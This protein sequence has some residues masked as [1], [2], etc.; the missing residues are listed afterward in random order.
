MA[1]KFRKQHRDSLKLKIKRAVKNLAAG[2]FNT[3]SSQVQ[4]F[5][6][7]KFKFKLIMLSAITIVLTAV[8]TIWYLWEVPLLSPLSSLSNFQFLPAV[9]NKQTQQQRIVYGF[10]PYWNL[11][12]VS[13]Q[14]ELTHLS[15]FGLNIGADG[16]IRTKTEDG[17]LHPG[18]DKLDSDKLMELSHQVGNNG[19]Q[20]ELV[21]I[22]FESETIRQIINN[23]EAHQ[24]LILSLDSILLAYPISGINI[25]IEY[26]GEVNDELR[27]NFVKL[28]AKLDQ[29][30]ETKYDHVTLSIDMYATAAS[31]NQIWDVEAIGQYVDYIVVMAYDFHRRS[32][33]Q[34]GP[35]APLFGGKDLWDTDI[36]QNL[37]EFLLKVPREKILLGIPF[38]G[39]EWQVESRSAQSNTYPDSGRTASY[40]RVQEIL[41]QADQLQVEVNWDDTALCPY[42]SYVEDGEVYMIYYENPTSLSYKLEYVNQLDLA[43][44]AIWAL[45]YEGSTRELWDEVGKRM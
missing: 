6:Q 25:D 41:E 22:Q 31:S 16:T 38:Y 39:Y 5:N 44:I 27:S 1:K 18:Y 19:D 43:G 2:L 30:L 36:N 13:I 21:L 10:L 9:L 34:A 33:I 24:N 23:P 17:N 45:G 15:Y 37:R 20:V 7:H 40:E 28:I 11:D 3:I 42:L 8:F 35:V 12:T 4:A 26:L 32:S 29:H 14:P